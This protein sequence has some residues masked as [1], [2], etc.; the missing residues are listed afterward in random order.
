MVKIITKIRN[1]SILGLKKSI[2][3]KYGN[4]STSSTSKMRKIIAIKKKCIE[5]GARNFALG[6]NPHSNG[7]SFSW[8]FRDFSLN[9]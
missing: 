9:A 8:V 7:L 5:N 6:I 2:V 1:S 4:R 3:I